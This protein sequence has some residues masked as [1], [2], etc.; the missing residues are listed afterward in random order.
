MRKLIAAMTKVCEMSNNVKY[1][2]PVLIKML[3]C[4]VR[5]KGKKIRGDR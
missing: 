4:L 3:S 5:L 2:Y 1:S